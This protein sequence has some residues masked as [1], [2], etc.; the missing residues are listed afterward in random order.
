MLRNDLTTSTY[1]EQIEAIFFLY[2][3]TFTSRNF[4]ISFLTDQMKGCMS[5]FQLL[6]GRGG[7]GVNLNYRSRAV[8]MGLLRTTFFGMLF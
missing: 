4:P 1:L 6:R 5:N 8:A 3:T 7:G 2:L